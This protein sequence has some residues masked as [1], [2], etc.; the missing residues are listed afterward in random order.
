MQINIARQPFVPAFLTLLT[1]TIVVAC[2][3]PVP[4]GIMATQTI[5]GSDTIVPGLLLMPPNAAI[6]AFQAAHPI[7]SQV[8]AGMLMLFAGM[9]IGRLTVRYNLYSVST[10]LAIPLFAILIC[11][12]G[13]GSDYLTGFLSVAL[14]ALATKNL[15][16]ACTN[17]YGFDA[18]F[19]AALYL[20]LL[21]LIAPAALPMLLMLPL[22][23]L[24]FRRTLREAVVTL[25]GL[26]FVPLIVCYVNWGL[27]GSFAAPLV[28]FWA[29]FIQGVPFALFTTQ[30]L[31]YL[32][33]PAGIVLLTLISIFL[34]WGNAYAVGNKPR[35]LLILN[36]GTFFLTAVTLCTPSASAA[37]MALMAVPA[38]ILMPLLFVRI[39]RSISL[40]LYLLLLVAAVMNIF[41][42]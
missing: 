41:L 5:G 26:L 11:S 7:W 33:L 40:P 16:R 28:Q 34:F 10:C 30:P 17:G 22:G 21:V 25:A 14:T 36:I 6:A 37:N 18:L 35:Y 31:V 4:T 15:G 8:F 42:Q 39:H 29:T 32:V 27:G 19:R 24:V 2:T 23:V 13:T 9:S 20:G 38:T 3:L 12:L 1:L